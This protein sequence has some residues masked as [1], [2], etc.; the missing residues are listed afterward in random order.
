MKIKK[1][2]SKLISWSIKP[3]ICKT[4]CAQSTKLINDFIVYSIFNN[5][6]KCFFVIK[7]QQSIKTLHKRSH[8][9]NP[10]PSHKSFPILCYSFKYYKRN[11]DIFKI[12]RLKW[13]HFTSK[14][15]LLFHKFFSPKKFIWEDKCYFLVQ[16]F[17]ENESMIYS[18]GSSKFRLFKY[19]SWRE[20]NSP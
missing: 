4:F 16:N 15:L 19:Q 8:Y 7:K 5:F 9:S 13:L 11:T 2:Q 20:C 10:N 1:E 6:A 18:L 17:I 3:I 14:I 12:S